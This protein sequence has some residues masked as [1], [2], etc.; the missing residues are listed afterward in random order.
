MREIQLFLIRL[1]RCCYLHS[2]T[3][4]LT[5]LHI[6]LTYQPHIP[7]PLAAPSLTELSLQHVFFEHVSFLCQKNHF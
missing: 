5:A 3:H 6:H 2:N 4:R 1:G 7:A